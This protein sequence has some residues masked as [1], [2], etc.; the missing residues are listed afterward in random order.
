M[1]D[2]LADAI[3]SLVSTMSETVFGAELCVVVDA[4]ACCSEAFWAHVAIEGPARTHVWVGPSR[5]LVLRAAR[6]MLLAESVSDLDLEDAAREV[7]N[8]IAGNLKAVF[9]PNGGMGL[10]ELQTPPVGAGHARRSEV[11][12][13]IDGEPLSV[14]VDEHASDV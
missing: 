9:A 4:D 11:R 5:P 2:T 12:M 13:S 10:P 7:A 3:A 6:Q 8:I 1:S 14:L